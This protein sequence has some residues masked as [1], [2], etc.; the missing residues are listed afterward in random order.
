[1]KIEEYMQSLHAYSD[2]ENTFRAYREELTRFEAYLKNRGLRITQV[3]S[4]TILEYLAYREEHK[5]RTKAGQLKPATNSRTLSA[6]SGYFDWD[7][8]QNNGRRANPVT[9]IKR[10]RVKNKK[11]KPADEGTLKK[12][13]AGITDLRD[14]AMML[15]FL[16]SGLRLAELRQ[17]NRNSITLYRRVLPGGVVEYYG[18][19]NVLGK[20]NKERFFMVGPPAVL[21]I[22]AYLNECRSKDTAPELFRSSRKTR[23]SGRAI[24]QILEKWCKLLQLEHLHPHRL[25][26][27]FATRNYEAGM[28]LPVIAE[29]L[30]HES[31]STTEGYTEI[32]QARLLRE[33]YAASEYFRHGEFKSEHPLAA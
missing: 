11:P 29:L 1:M 4:T 21:A 31:L 5:G 2:S 30:G 20:G 32:P 18:S 14:L 6:L 27:S 9:P 12:L 26:H 15:C 25:R 8:V 23:L 19:G 17:L 16:C 24:E 28:T 22:R 33:Y 7:N 10:K 13:I 3:T